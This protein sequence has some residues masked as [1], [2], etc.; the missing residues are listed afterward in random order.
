LRNETS[1]ISAIRYISMFFNSE[2]VMVIYESGKDNEFEKFKNQ[3]R[4][5]MQEKI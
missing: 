1:F 2:V 3:T 5:N 4:T